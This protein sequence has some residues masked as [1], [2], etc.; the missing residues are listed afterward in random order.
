MDIS[1]LSDLEMQIANVIEQ[2][3]DSKTLFKGAEY[4]RQAGNPT[5]E[6]AHQVLRFPRET[7]RAC[8]IYV[9]LFKR[10]IGEGDFYWDEPAVNVDPGDVDP[11]DVDPWEEFNRKQN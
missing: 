7:L 2:N 9:E 1:I 5:V 10:E 3:L 8:R 6:E 4:F 11:W